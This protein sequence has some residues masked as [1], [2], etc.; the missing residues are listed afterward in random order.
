MI[1]LKV[2]LR[3]CEYMFNND[4]LYSHTIEKENPKIVALGHEYGVCCINVETNQCIYCNK[5]KIKLNEVLCCLFDQNYNNLYFTQDNKVYKFDL[6]QKS[7]NF[8]FE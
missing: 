8:L 6:R 7:I 4:I 1:K 3:A 2:E 5:S